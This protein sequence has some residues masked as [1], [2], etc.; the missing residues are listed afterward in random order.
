MSIR[1]VNKRMIAAELMVKKELTNVPLL[2]PKMNSQSREKKKEKNLKH[3]Y[4]AEKATRLFSQ[5]INFI[6]LLF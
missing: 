2:T 6:N 5:A 3:K 4:K 1:S